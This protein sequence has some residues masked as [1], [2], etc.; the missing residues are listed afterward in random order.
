MSTNDIHFGPGLPTLRSYRRSFWEPGET[1]GV[2]FFPGKT[3]P[4]TLLYSDSPE[5]EARLMSLIDGK[6]ISVDLEWAPMFVKSDHI[7]ELFQFA[8]TKGVV[9]VANVD[10]KGLD[11]LAAFF[12]ASKF[13][14][15]GTSSDRKR[16]LSCLGVD[17]P[18][19]DVEVTRLTPNHLSINF[20]EMVLQN[21][22]EGCAKFKDHRMQISDW[23]KRPLSVQQVLYG[24][25][26]AY[27]MLLVYEHLI[28]KYGPEIK[29][30][31][32]P[33]KKPKRE[34]KEKKCD[35]EITIG[36]VELADLLA[37]EEKVVYETSDEDPPEKLFTAVKKKID[38]SVASV[39][40]CWAKHSDRVVGGAFGIKLRNV[41]IMQIAADL[42]LRGVS[43]IR[44]DKK[45]ICIMCD[46]SFAGF[47]AFGQHSL[48]YHAPQELPEVPVDIKKTFLNYMIATGVVNCPYT[49]TFGDIPLRNS[50]PPRPEEEEED[51]EEEEPIRISPIV[52]DA[53][54]GLSCSL[55]PDVKFASPEEVLEH[56]WAAHW[57]TFF[58][59]MHEGTSKARDDKLEQLGAICVNK[60]GLGTPDS[61]GNGF[62]C[63]KCGQ[64]MATP[65]KLFGHAVNRHPSF[66]I[67]TKSEYDQWPLKVESLPAS[68][69]T[70]VKKM[71]S[72][73]DIPSLTEHGILGEDGTY[74]LICKRHL[75]P[76]YVTDHF[77]KHHLVFL[78]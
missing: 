51:E 10:N 2:E 16:L 34:K 46:K 65:T 26:D 27:A 50:E 74:C 19:E 61:D 4:V 52:Y 17:V 77:V 43:G 45:L 22:G 42:L 47:S 14:G 58:A 48:D 8:S 24:A 30:L 28:A 13:F 12:G 67:P 20:E 64:K 33:A 57:Q 69:Q 49:L 54:K 66:G 63:A 9:V 41:R 68:L 72:G 55:C 75:M 70:L 73:I 3:V 53:E 11:T 6:P 40:E 37:K 5:L 18:I 44:F 21:V 56:C 76:A 60:F 29:V 59:L 36:F 78:P 39:E 7:I 32:A 38:P 35:V 62:I 23:S 71:I 15:K 1:R 31:P 25:H